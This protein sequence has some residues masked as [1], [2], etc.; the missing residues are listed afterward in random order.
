M[1]ESKSNYYII[2]AKIEATEHF[3]FNTQCKTCNK[4]HDHTR[5][6]ENDTEWIKPAQ[7]FTSPKALHKDQ[8]W[9]LNLKASSP[10]DW[11]CFCR[12]NKASFKATRLFNQIKK[13]TPIKAF[14][15]YFQSFA[16]RS[17]CWKTR[18][19]RAFCHFCW[20]FSDNPTI[21]RAQRMC[22]TLFYWKPRIWKIG[23]GDSRWQTRTKALRLLCCFMDS[24]ERKIIRPLVRCRA[25]KG[26]WERNDGVR[27]RNCAWTW[28]YI[29][30]VVSDVGTPWAEPKSAMAC[31]NR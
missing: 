17:V 11:C 14:K 10:I 24:W 20:Y 4:Y 6:E 30:L 29:Y 15:K 2:S 26:R 28:M 22:V 5:Y 12:A 18:D 8:A 27:N 16:R 7:A 19:I 13:A 25:Q 3:S 23:P 31:Q 1:K 21:T 9:N